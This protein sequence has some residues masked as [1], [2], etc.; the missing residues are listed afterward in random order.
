M[1]PQETLYKLYLDNIAD[2]KKQK[3]RTDGDGVTTYKTK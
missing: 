3:T 2:F 1:N